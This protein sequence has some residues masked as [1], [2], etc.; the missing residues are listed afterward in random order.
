MY[1]AALC[2]FTGCKPA[3]N[4]SDYIAYIN[5][6]E[7]K[8]TQ[9]IK[10]DDVQISMKWLPET[11]RR[12]IYGRG[13]YDKDSPVKDDGL[14]YFNARFDKE[15]GEKPGKEKNLYLDFDM[16][17]DFVLLNGKDSIAPVFCQKIENGIGGSYEYMLAF[18]RPAGIINDFSVIYNDK[19]FGVGTVAF[20]YRNEDIMKIPIFKSKDQ[21]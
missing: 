15:K 4:E 10:L 14:Y 1:L 6:P 2:W 16:Q 19:I 13:N 8:I 11:Y 9:R 20:V 17:Q 3:Q 12:I 5:N 21:E 7:N 18:E